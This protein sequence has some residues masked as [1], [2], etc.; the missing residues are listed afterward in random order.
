MVHQRDLRLTSGE[1]L[2]AATV[3]T[4]AAPT[5]TGV[6]LVHGMGSDRHANT[7]RAAA[8][9][10]RLGATALA[11]DL[12]GHGDSTGR[13]SEVTPRQNLQ[14]LVAAFD[15]LAAEPG[16]DPALVSAC[17]ASYGAYLSVLLTEARPVTRLVLRAPALYTDDS[18]DRPLGKRRRGGPGVPALRALSRY[19]GPVLLVESERDEVIPPA[20]VA[21]YRAAR[22]GIAHA[23]LPGASHAL[24]NPAWRTAYTDL[25]VDFLGRA[26]DC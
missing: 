4:P 13:L 19:A 9:A 12:G 16:V 23:V 11:V 2:L 17:G 26:T 8:L 14:D 6:L 15:A 25:V 5:G 3:A 22:P 7:D 10:G 24:T 20:L 18:F 21:A 1:R